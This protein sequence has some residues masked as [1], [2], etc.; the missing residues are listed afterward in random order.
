MVRVVTKIL[1]YWVNTTNRQGIKHLVFLLVL[2]FFY[3]PLKVA[4]DQVH[5][6][7]GNSWPLPLN[8]SPDGYR[9]CVESNLVFNHMYDYQ[10]HF[11]II[12][13]SVQ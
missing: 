1:S 12:T 9:T 7:L 13:H 5:N 11:L 3:F 4:R 6:S 10:V 2:Y 8:E